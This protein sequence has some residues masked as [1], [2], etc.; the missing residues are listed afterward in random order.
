MLNSFWGKFGQRE[1]Q[2]KTTITHQ[3]YDLFKALTDPA[4]V[5]NNVMPINEKCITINWEYKHEIQDSLPFTN[6]CI[7]AYTTTQARLKLYEYLEKLEE[8]VLYYDTDSILYISK[9][10][11]YEPKTGTCIGEMTNELEVYG[12]DSYINEFVSGGPKN[13]AYKVWSTKE[14]KEKVVCKVKGININYETSKLINFSTMKDLVLGTNA[15]EGKIYVKSTAFR[16]TQNREVI[17]REETKAYRINSTKRKFEGNSSLPYG[18]KK[19]KH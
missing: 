10:G 7:A 14:K 5:V 6:V 4:V 3:P 15:D 1:N 8:R 13:Y 2:P 12:A 16:R 19:Q 17:T 9:D 11:E 18:Y